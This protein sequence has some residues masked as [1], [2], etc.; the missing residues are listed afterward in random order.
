ME[1]D[2]PGVASQSRSLLPGASAEDFDLLERADGIPVW[3]Q[4]E[5][6]DDETRNRYLAEIRDNM[7]VYRPPNHSR[8][9]TMNPIRP[10]LVGALEFQSVL[11]SLEKSRNTSYR[12][13]IS[14]RSYSDNPNDHQSFDTRSIAS[15]PR[16]SRP[17][18][19]DDHLSPPSAA[20]RARAV[21]ANDAYGLKLDTTVL[22]VPAGQAPRL[23]V[24]RPS[25]DGADG[26]GLPRIDSTAMLTAS[27]SSSEFPSANTSPVE[28]TA[29]QTPNLLVP[30]GA[31]N[32]PNYEG[33][34]VNSDMSASVSPRG[35][36][37]SMKSGPESP[38]VP[39]PTYMDD[40]NA[41]S[42]RPPTS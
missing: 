16:A 13:N 39:F 11:R 19:Q 30:P 28:T 9:N 35:T 21:S 5:E 1:D 31:F 6:E 29:P 10:S 22:N 23:T 34:A 18:A 20:S 2:D 15:H 17:P 26:A 38:A 36:L 40:P 12:P 24:R 33:S 8:R 42:S 25:N 37:N 3:K 41:P 27:P 32:S 7:H 4:E 14:L